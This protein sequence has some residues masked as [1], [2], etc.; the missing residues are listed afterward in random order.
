VYGTFQLKEFERRE[1]LKDLNTGGRIILK[2]I[3]NKL[4]CN[5]VDWIQMDLDMF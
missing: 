2:C 5:A 3:L 1:H 4:Q